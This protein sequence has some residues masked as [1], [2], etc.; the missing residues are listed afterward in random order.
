MRS[1]CGAIGPGWALGRGLFAGPFAGRLAGR[2]PTNAGRVWP[3]LLINQTTRQPDRPTTARAIGLGC[4]AG[5]DR[6]RFGPFGRGFA[7]LIGP[8]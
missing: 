5:L 7:G 2:M 3:G 1:V 6:G 4:L 8:G